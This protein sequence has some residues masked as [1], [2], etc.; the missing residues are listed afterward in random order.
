MQF[1]ILFNKNKILFGNFVK[2]RNFIKFH[3]KE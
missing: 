3:T 2:F 1:E